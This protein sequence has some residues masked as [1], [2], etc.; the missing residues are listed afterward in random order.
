MK[1]IALILVISLLSLTNVSRGSP[2]QGSQVQKT[3]SVKEKLEKI[4]NMLDYMELSYHFKTE[5]V[6]KRR[7]NRKPV[8]T[9]I[10]VKQK[11]IILGLLNLE[12]GNIDFMR[13]RRDGDSIVNRSTQYDIKFEN[14][15][16]K[17]KWN[18]YNTPFKVKEKDSD[19]WDEW[20][21]GG[22][23]YPE[24]D[25]RDIVYIPYSTGLYTE[26]LIN[27]GKKYLKSDIE[28]ALFELLVMGVCSQAYPGQN[29]TILTSHDVAIR[30]IL[31]EHT[32]P[33]E[34]KEFKTG[35]YKFNPFNRVFVRIGTN[36]GDTFLSPNFAGAAGLTQFTN[37]T[38]GRRLG[39]WDMVKRAYPEIKLSSFRSGALNHKE[40][41][42]AMVCLHDLNAR[43]LTEIFGS[44]ILNHPNL[45]YFLAAAY[46]TGVANVIRSIRKYGKEANNW[47]YGL[48]HQETRD[49][50][51]KLDFLIE[52]PTFL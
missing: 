26:E 13:I 17:L 34:F 31:I 51:E 49:Y 39:T 21:V 38:K 11:D 50:L 24:N 42:K 35:N 44:S 22:I 6:T 46:N 25:Y 3:Y 40:S 5:Y 19:D 15:P 1:K 28:R 7:R 12:N 48:P 45:E 10:T 20:V 29:V 37:N 47:R 27:A 2:N 14:P 9:K 18:T 16:S 4:Q 33:T 41:I 36:E 32:D 52:N 30:L 23:K 43:S 8:R